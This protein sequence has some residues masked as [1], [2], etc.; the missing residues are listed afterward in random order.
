[1]VAPCFRL[2][3][4]GP[5]AADC[6]RCYLSSMARSRPSWIAP[7]F[8]H[9]G[10]PATFPATL[11]RRTAFGCFTPDSGRRQ[12]QGVA[13]S[14]GKRCGCDAVTGSE[15]C[16]LHGGARFLERRAQE[17]NPG[18]RLA[19][20]RNKAGRRLLAA[21]GAGELP[22][23]FPSHVGRIAVSELS[24][25]ARGRL[26]EAW[27]NRELD[28]ATWRQCVDTIETSETWQKSTKARRKT[29]T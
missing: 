18:A 2:R 8:S 19:P 16:H 15:Y 1:M 4:G 9:P 28:P 13:R 27:L 24:S 10:N 29:T 3:A 7:L 22:E 23:G 6:A 20:G 26:V 25:T 5:F 12:C 17:W 11:A 21:I 14:T